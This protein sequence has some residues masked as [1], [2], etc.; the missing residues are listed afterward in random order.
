[1]QIVRST[2]KGKPA[3]QSRQNYVD[4]CARACVCTYIINVYNTGTRKQEMTHR[5]EDC[6]QISNDLREALFARTV[7]TSWKRV[8]HLQTRRKLPLKPWRSRRDPRMIVSATAGVDSTCVR[9]RGNNGS[10]RIG[11]LKLNRRLQP[12][13]SAKLIQALTSS[14]IANS[15]V[16]PLP[17]KITSSHSIK[18][19]PK[20][21]RVKNVDL[22]SPLGRGGGGEGRRGSTSG[23]AANFAALSGFCPA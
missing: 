3:V 16:A 7:Q 11:R 20:L 15:L 17:A 22:H 6:A 10:F 1:M 2:R 18:H 21:Y 13:V 4:A 9:K 5:G 14:L 8:K 19:T 23:R 12:D